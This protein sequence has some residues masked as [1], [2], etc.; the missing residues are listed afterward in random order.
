MEV[1]TKELKTYEDYAKLPEG[2]PYQLI[3]GEF[4]MSPAPDLYH[5]DVS[6]NIYDALKSLV[7]KRKLGKV[8]YAPV[9][10]SLSEHNT[11]QPDIV[12][13]SNERM[14][15]LQGERIVGAPD[16]VVEI[17]SPTT[18]YY[19]LATKKDTYEAHGVKEYWVVDPKGKTIEVFEN[20]N[21]RFVSI[22]K[23]REKGIV[24][25]HLLAELKLEVEEVFKA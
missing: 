19:D 13:V 7:R 11:F 17:L 1:A 10:V 25:S 15:I 16:L 5:Q 6:A 2:A 14:H 4:V 18:G 20:V 24:S 12:F 3:D 8:Y 9:D 23:E 21:G 22:V